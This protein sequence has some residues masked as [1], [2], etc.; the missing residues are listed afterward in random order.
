MGIPAFRQQIS[1]PASFTRTLQGDREIVAA[2]LY[3]HK[4]LWFDFQGLIDIE[5][6][7]WFIDLDGPFDANPADLA[8]IGRNQ[9]HRYVKKRLDY[10]DRIH[11]LI[12]KG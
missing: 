2:A 7:F 8:K 11:E 12:V 5:G 10:L 3:G 4:T 9:R 1:D 6:N